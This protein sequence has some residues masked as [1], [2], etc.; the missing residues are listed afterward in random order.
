VSDGTL[1][2]EILIQFRNEDNLFWA[3]YV[4][5]GVDEGSI[6]GITSIDL[7]NNNKIALRG[8]ENNFSLWVNGSKIAED[9]TVSMI[10]NGTLDRVNLDRGDG[11]ENLSAKTKGIIYI[12]E[13][14][15]D[16]QMSELTSN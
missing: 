8:K 16:T 11:S 9:L 4:K 1:N 15:T 7:Y 14:Y 13:Y 3:K 12:N 10:P 2:N 5:G 6:T